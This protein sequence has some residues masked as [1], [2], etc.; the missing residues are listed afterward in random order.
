MSEDR[1]LVESI[2]SDED[3]AALDDDTK[4][5]VTKNEASESDSSSSAS[6]DA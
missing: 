5:R 4:Q 2:R 1:E 3:F 6:A